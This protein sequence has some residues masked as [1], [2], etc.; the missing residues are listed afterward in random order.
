VS[1]DPSRL[2]CARCK[3]PLRVVSMT[4]AGTSSAC[5]CGAFSTTYL[6]MGTLDLGLVEPAPA[7]EV[8]VHNPELEPQSPT[9]TPG[10]G[11]E[12]C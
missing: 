8:W 3:T 7:G 2:V 1:D 5:D 9:D 11:Q 6:N 12:G 10:Q 4:A